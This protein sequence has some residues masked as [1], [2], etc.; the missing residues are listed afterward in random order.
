MATIRQVA[1]RA[2]VS[3]ATVSYV[4]NDVRK[5]RPETE[6]RVLTA[7]RELGYHPNAAARSLVV[8]RSSILGLVVPDIENPFFPEIT[9]SFQETASAAGMETIVINTNYDMQ[10]TRNAVDR[11]VSLQVPGAAFLTSQIDTSIK[12]SLAKRNIPA[13]YMD[14]AV[15]GV[16]AGN[17]VIDYE[18]G[19][20]QAFDH[21]VKLGHRRI[22]LI[23]GPAHG[24]TAQ[25]RKQAFLAAAESAGVD[26]RVIE[27]DFTVQGGYFSCSRLLGGFDA[28]AV[29]AANDLMAIGALHCAYD[30]QL[31]VP[32]SL[33]VVGF[34]DI[35]FAQF[36][37]PAL[38]TVAVPRAEIGQRAFRLLWSMISRENGEETRLDVKTT[39]KI[40]QTTA[41]SPA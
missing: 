18:G 23:G 28:T 5:V 3:V 10:R 41:A 39:L 30:R 31:S 19:I 4:L 22:G 1:E 6:Q 14:H 36:T 17:I 21:L 35:T 2:G 40:R 37:Q 33:S 29:I 27:S 26:Q 20:A 34:D 13:I 38:T 24:A 32:A 15:G 9:K 16:T 7:A 12:E 8:G 11:L 25:R